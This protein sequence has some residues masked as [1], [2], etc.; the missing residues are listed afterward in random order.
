MRIGRLNIQL[1]PKKKDNPEKLTDQETLLRE[2]LDSHIK[3]VKINEEYAA[4]FLLLLHN[5]SLPKDEAEE[6]EIIK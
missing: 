1:L 6:V 3:W 4:G 5:F 2:L